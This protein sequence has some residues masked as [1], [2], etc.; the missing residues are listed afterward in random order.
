MLASSRVN[1]GSLSGAPGSQG[2]TGSNPAAQLPASQLHHAAIGELLRLLRPGSN[3]AYTNAAAAA[4]AAAA[5]AAA[6]TAASNAAAA[7]AGAA[8]GAAA[9]AAITCGDAGGAAAAAETDLAPLPLSVEKPWDPPNTAASPA[10]TKAA[11]GATRGGAKGRAGR[12]RASGVSAG[13]GKK[14]ERSRRERFSDVESFWRSCSPQ[15]RLQLLRV[16]LAPL[17]AGEYL[18]GVQYLGESIMVL[19][20]GGVQLAHLGS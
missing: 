10:G 15:Q 17:L 1:T 20:V 5:A 8:A 18:D 7:A 16:P 9:P 13:A 3:Q 14:R 2:S 12:S 4:T 6:A 11:T 19:S